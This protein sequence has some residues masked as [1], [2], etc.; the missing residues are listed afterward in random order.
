[1]VDSRVELAAAEPLAAV[2][3][4]QEPARPELRL[5]VGGEVGLLFPF[6]IDG[7]LLLERGQQHS[8][9][10]DLS[11]QPSAYWQSYSVGGAYHPFGNAWFAGGRVRW[12]QLHAPWSR[13]YDS[14]FD[15]VLGLGLELGARG[16][17]DRGQRVLGTAALGVLF[18][19]SGDTS[20][21]VLYTLSLGVAWGAVR[22][23]LGG[24]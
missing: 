22:T 1:T 10:L 19:P 13:G 21:P 5:A 12:L 6:G 9:D 18:V 24:S 3:T 11:W 7:L 16:W 2:P 20:L 15:N 14:D 17:F 8:L 4:T 23:P